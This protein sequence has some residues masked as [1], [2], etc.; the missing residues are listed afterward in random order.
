MAEGAQTSVHRSVAG[1]GTVVDAYDRGRPAY[2]GEA[3]AWV[4][5]QAAVSPGSDLLDLAA[6]TGKLTRLLLP[7][8]ARVIAVEP[9][10]QFR[11]ALAALSVDVRDGTAESI[12]LPTASVDLV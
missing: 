3:V 2:P 9:V 6:G 1:Y 10:A 5:Q 12:P 7:S 4:L 11:E 8:E